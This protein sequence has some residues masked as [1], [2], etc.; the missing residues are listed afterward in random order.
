MKKKRIIAV[1]TAALLGISASPSGVLAADS[2]QA[3]EKAALAK[4]LKQFAATYAKDLKNY[5]P[6]TTASVVNF[7]IKLEDAGR[8][9][10]GVMFPADISWFSDV[11]MKMNVGVKDEQVTELGDICVNGTKILTFEEY[12]DPKTSV[13]HMRIPEISDAFIKV[14]P[15]A[16]N[17]AVMENSDLSDDS[18]NSYDPETMMAV[19]DFYTNLSANIPEA[20]VIRNILDRYTT[21]L[22]NGTVEGASG[23]E[24]MTASGVSQECTVFE[25][26]F[27]EAEAIPAFTEFFTTAK[28]D[29]ELKNLI[30]TYSAPLPEGD[31]VYSTFQEKIDELLTHI[32]EE[33]DSTDDFFFTSR[34]W[35]DEKDNIIGRQFCTNDN[36]VEQPVITWKSPSD[37]ET[38]GFQ[39][40]FNADDV[41]LS[42][43]GT[44]TGPDGHY[45]FSVNSAP[46][47][48][49]EMTNFDAEAY[50]KGYFNGSYTFSILPGIGDD[51]AYN[52]LRSFTLTADIASD[53]TDSDFTLTIASQGAPFVTMSMA[54]SLDDSVE[55]PVVSAFEDAYDAF[56]T[57]D[58]E[59][60][61]ESLNT[62]VL[63]ENLSAA[64]MPDTFVE[65][66][67]SAFSAGEDSGSYEDDYEDGGY[68]AEE[69]PEYEGQ[70]SETSGSETP[71]SA[72]G[73]DLSAASM[74]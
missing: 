30:E 23:P 14:D 70:E 26:L 35:V 47:V 27:S 63:F 11:S 39:L 13:I 9:L 33:P 57:D 62:D 8:A 16:M 67:M 42:L 20:D 64:G 61:V 44:C 73:R 71:D 74:I 53:E 34:I 48:G 43:D 25:G 51:N 15:A 12:P 49:I 50:E 5:D 56:N 32:P 60:Y 58:M 36:G 10:L 6:A 40:A 28:E 18:L 59:A 7:T 1:L 65:D 46:V 4:G 55:F 52:V 54:A 72:K 22:I 17:A 2:Y 68:N 45:E 24:T 21:I 19:S 38:D 37:G 29:E 66:I 3:A 31:S 41:E 69:N